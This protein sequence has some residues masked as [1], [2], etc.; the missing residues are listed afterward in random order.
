MRRS[1]G[2]GFSCVLLLAACGGQTAE[3]TLV[4][5][6]M[7]SDPLPIQRPTPEAVATDVGTPSALVLDGD[8]VVFTTRATMLSGELVEAG[9]LFVA[10]KRVA[11]AL[12]IGLDREGATYLALATDGHDAFVATS[13]ARLV[14]VPLR[15][16]DTKELATLD[17][18][19]AQ[20]AVSTNYLYF[21]TDGHVGRIPKTGGAVENVVDV[22]SRGLFAKDDAVFVAADDSITR[23]DNGVTKA[24]AQTKGQPCAVAHDEGQLFWTAA[25]TQQTT[26]ILKVGLEGGDATTIASGS[27]A[28]CA[29]AAD[30]TSL[31]F[32][33]TLPG[34]LPVRSSGTPGLGLMRAPLAG[35]A[36]VA[37][38][39]AT[40]ALAA[41]GA[42]AVDGVHLYWLTS[43]SVM[44]LA[45]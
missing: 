17:G 7:P 18:P 27:F 33:T 26:S 32:A 15:G 36:P 6:T 43:T 40:H 5:E 20:I 41:P 10:D 39:E 19:A 24:I 38:T 37:I 28:A 34:A 8:L 31:Y 29:L 23:I 25:D 2:F 1:L 22:R 21:A 44:R 9:A 16:G 35:G 14:S 3:P 42:V 12:M 30:G 45:K 11:P 4:T 13:D